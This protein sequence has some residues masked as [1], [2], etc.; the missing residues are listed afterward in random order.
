MLQNFYF[1]RYSHEIYVKLIFY[2]S[3]LQTILF[4]LKMQFHC[5]QLNGHKTKSKLTMARGP[6]LAI[7]ADKGW[8]S[9][10]TESDSES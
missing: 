8:F 7:A 6:K 1:A 5:L 9:L 2:F 3:T 10:A 4:P